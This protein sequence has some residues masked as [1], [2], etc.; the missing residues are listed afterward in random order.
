[1]RTGSFLL[2]N[3]VVLAPMAGVTDRPF[4]QLCRRL[5]A[6]LTVSEMVM[7][8]PRLR[9]T[10]KTRRRIDHCGEPA[11]RSVQIA[12]ETFDAGRMMVFRPGDEITATAGPEGARLMALGGALIGSRRRR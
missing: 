9:A 11:P 1:M 8:D 7:S 5:G 3:R 12:G 10:R 2:P 4:R 6:G